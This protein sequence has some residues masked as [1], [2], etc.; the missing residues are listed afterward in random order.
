[1]A[2][3][4]DLSNN[5]NCFKS[6]YEQGFVDLSGGSIQTRNDD[7]KLIIAGDASLNNAY[8]GEYRNVYGVQLGHMSVGCDTATA[9]ANNYKLDISGTMD[10]CGNLFSSGDISLNNYLTTT[11]INT[12]DIESIT[13]NNNTKTELEFVGSNDGEGWLCVNKDGDR[14]AHKNMYDTNLYIYDSSGNLQ[15]TIPFAANSRYVCLFDALP[16]FSMIAVPYGSSSKMQIFTKTNSFQKGVNEGYDM[17]SELILSGTNDRVGRLCTRLRKHPITNEIYLC[18]HDR[19]AGIECFIY[20]S[21]NSTWDQL[22]N[23]IT[24]GVTY[25]GGTGDWERPGYMAG[26]YTDFTITENGTLIIC[27]CSSSTA[28]IKIRQYSSLA[29]DW[30]LKD[31]KRINAHYGVVNISGLFLTGDGTKV[32]T[33]QFAMG[34]GISL[35]EINSDFTFGTESAPITTNSYFRNFRINELGTVVVGTTSGSYNGAYYFRLKSDNT[36][37]TTT[38]T[39]DNNGF[40]YSVAVSYYGD[41]FVAGDNTSNSKLQ[42]NSMTDKTITYKQEPLQLGG[43]MFIGNDCSVNGIITSGSLSIDN[44]NVSFSEDTNITQNRLVINNNDKKLQKMQ[45]TLTAD[46]SSYDSIPNFKDSTVY[47]GRSVL[48]SNGLVFVSSDPQDGSGSNRGHVEVW[49]RDS[50]ESTTWTNTYDFYNTTAIYYGYKLSVNSDGTRVAVYSLNAYKGRIDILDYD[51]TNWNSSTNT[52]AEG[53][54]AYERQGEG[55]FLSEN[56]NKIIYDRQT[57]GN[58]DGLYDGPTEIVVKEY[59]GTD[60]SSGGSAITI[61]T[62]DRWKLCGVSDDFTTFFVCKSASGDMTFRVYTYSSS[63][64]TNVATVVAVANSVYSD[65]TTDVYTSISKNGKYIVFGNY[66]YEGNSTRTSWSLVG[67]IVNVNANGINYK[68]Y[69]RINDDGN[70]IVYTSFYSADPT[71]ITN[72]P[73]MIVVE[74]ENNVWVQKYT[75]LNGSEVFGSSISNKRYVGSQSKIHKLNNQYYF[76][77]N[78]YDG[79][80]IYKIPYTLKQLEPPIETQNINS[81]GEFSSG[82]SGYNIIVPGNITIIDSSAN[83]YGAYTVYTTKDAST[84]F[85]VGKSASNVFNIVNQNNAGVYM[86]SGNNSLT[87]TSDIRLKK[88]IEPLE[89]ATER[90]MKLNPCTYK[91][92]TQTDEKRHVGFI[93]QEVEEVFPEL[94]RETTYPDGSTYKGV[95]TEDLVGYLIK[96]MENQ[97]RRLKLLEETK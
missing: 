42:I 46:M 94:V 19:W 92:K 73:G 81:S 35:I 63:S 47:G 91:W 28:Y 9:T 70:I 20:N 45:A 84:H 14:I 17:H 52:I 25:Y 10:I 43:N 15:T 29:N 87:S 65:I 97:D 77:G 89:D 37:E 7:Q 6:I 80:I 41:Y 57:D 75:D 54:I 2:N 5:A 3:W 39:G 53:T 36:W 95:A 69:P 96:V 30:I 59:D 85:S 18:V 27:Y 48:S 40:G 38:V 1:M 74:L 60:W 90:I 26:Y 31:Q 67:D 32:F 68:N 58:T 4:L 55:N 56:G 82:G 62:G 61:D 86:V 83:N 88:E 64:W 76:S 93:A 66:V 78:W 13:I 12:Q 11:M 22:G 34:G 50:L 16:D 8:L 21:I 71:G 33:N 72:S 24:D 51:G 49:K 23:E 79:A 44:I